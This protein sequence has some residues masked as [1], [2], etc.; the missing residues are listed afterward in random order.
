MLILSPKQSILDA[1][2]VLERDLSLSYKHLDDTNGWR[3]RRKYYEDPSDCQIHPGF[4]N[5]SPG[6]YCSGQAV[7]AFLCYRRG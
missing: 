7:R 5:M 4:V 2:T 6:W 1:D 3:G